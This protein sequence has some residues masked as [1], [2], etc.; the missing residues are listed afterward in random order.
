MQV[1]SRLVQHQ[2]VII[3]EV[4]TSAYVFC[5]IFAYLAWWKKP[6]GCT[7]PH[8]IPCSEEAIDRMTADNYK[9]VA[10]TYREYVWGGEDWDAQIVP[11]GDGDLYAF[12]AFPIL[13]GAVHVA[14][15]KAALPSGGELWMWRV[16]TLLCIA[17]PSLLGSMVLSE[18]RQ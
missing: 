5:A 8:V 13:F 16:S 6:Q 11:D 4:S 3:L 18:D 17:I 15:W 7:M 9:S 10:G 2:E 1:L 12:L 14:S